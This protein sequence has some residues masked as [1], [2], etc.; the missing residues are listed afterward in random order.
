MPVQKE[1]V[2][3]LL[4]SDSLNKLHRSAPGL[5]KCLTQET[6]RDTRLSKAKTPPPGGSLEGVRPGS[7]H[8]PL[9]KEHAPG[10]QI[11]GKGSWDMVPR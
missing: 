8:A 5:P 2:A 11:G 6:Q 7:S 10:R 9:G 4:P 3:T 1:I